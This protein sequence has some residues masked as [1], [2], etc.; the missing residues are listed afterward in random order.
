MACCKTAAEQ[1]ALALNHYEYIV[2][3]KY[4]IVAHKFICELEIYRE[5]TGVT[6]TNDRQLIT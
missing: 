4:C 5:R 6:S 1:K 3:V 2:R